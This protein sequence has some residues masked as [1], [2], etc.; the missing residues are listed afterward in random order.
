MGYNLKRNGWFNSFM[1]LKNQS[2]R[3]DGV[4][5]RGAREKRPK[6]FSIL[7]SALTDKDDIILDWQCGVGIFFHL[8]CFDFF[9]SFVFGCPFIS[10]S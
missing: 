7:L 1:D 4:P 2:M 9:I 8:F 10:L 5:W 6:F 3:D